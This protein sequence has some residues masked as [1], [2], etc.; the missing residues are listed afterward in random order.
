MPWHQNL[1]I[2]F[3][4]PSAP[5][6]AAAMECVA[7][8]S[9]LCGQTI[10]HGDIFFCGLVHL[11]LG[12]PVFHLLKITCAVPSFYFS[13]RCM[14]FE[15]AVHNDYNLFSCTRN[16]NA[17]N[18]FQVSVAATPTSQGLTVPSVCF[19]HQLLCLKA[20]TFCVRPTILLQPVTAPLCAVKT[21]WT[22][23]DSLSVF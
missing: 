17:V 14:L 21:S 12:M 3:L 6:T 9:M 19:W 20:A 15:S 13:S 16:T 7:M 10:R 22:V 4:T 2:P 18:V 23:W 1:T 11:M 5:T 8:V